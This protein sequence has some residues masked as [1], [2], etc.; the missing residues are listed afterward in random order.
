[1][2]RKQTTGKNGYRGRRRYAA[3]TASAPKGPFVGVL[4][5]N[6]AGFG[7]VRQEEGRD[8]FIRRGNMAG[9]MHGDTV[10][11]DLLPEYLWER[12]REGIVDKV[13]VRAQTEVVGTFQRN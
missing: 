1:M 4:E 6:K 8:I 7:F 3:D 13:L 10:Q 2:M 11:A 5:K 9:A 12:N